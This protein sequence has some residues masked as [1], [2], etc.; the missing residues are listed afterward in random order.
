[1]K[2]RVQTLGNSIGPSGEGVPAI[3]HGKRTGAYHYRV[4]RETDTGTAAIHSRHAFY[5]HARASVALDRARFTAA[6][7]NFMHGVARSGGRKLHGAC[8]WGRDT[9]RRRSAPVRARMIHH[10]ILLRMEAMVV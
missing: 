6:F 1:M 7:M 4:L 5:R 10:V 9:F 2:F 3:F 8:G